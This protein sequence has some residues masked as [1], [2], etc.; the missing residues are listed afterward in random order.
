[1]K[2]PDDIR[3]IYTDA[4]R[5]HETFHGMENNLQNW[6]DLAKVSDEVCKKHG[7]HPLMI[8]LAVAVSEQLEREVI[9]T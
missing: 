2:I 3:A 6:A 9:G 8:A 7:N 1:M 5:L 4:Y